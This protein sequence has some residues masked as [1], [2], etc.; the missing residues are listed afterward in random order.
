M[1][2]LSSVLRFSL[3]S[4]KRF[5]VQ[6]KTIFNASFSIRA[7]V[8]SSPYFIFDT[9]SQMIVFRS[10]AVGTF[11]IFKIV[12][13]EACA[14]LP[15]SRVSAGGVGNWSKLLKY[16]FQGHSKKLFSSEAETYLSVYFFVTNFV[17]F[18]RILFFCSST[19]SSAFSIFPI[20]LFS[21]I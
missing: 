9:F 21:K 17:K 6:T 11:F 14:T 7:R 5:F 10:S 13:I 4:G 8:L 1:E 12:S 18:G 16:H 3:I 2:R 15:N 19:S 20:F